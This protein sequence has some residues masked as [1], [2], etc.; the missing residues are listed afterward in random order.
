[1]G[2]SMLNDIFIIAFRLANIFRSLFAEGGLNNVFTPTFTSLLTKNGRKDAIEFAASLRSILTVSLLS[3]IA[4]MMIFMPS[5][6]R[7]IAPGLS[8]SSPQYFQLAVHLARIIFPY[9]FF[10]TLV[11]FYGCMLASVNKFS[12]FSSTPIILN[13][14]M[15]IAIAL[16]HFFETPAHA[17][18]YAVILAGLLELLW[19]TYSANLA[20]LRLPIAK[21]H[22][23]PTTKKMLCLMIPNV[24]SSSITQ[25]MLW[26]NTI[27]A[28]SIVGAVSYFYFADRII[29]LPMALVGTTISIITLPN[30]SK[31]FAVNDNSKVSYIITHSICIITLLALPSLVGLLQLTEEIVEILFMHG[32]FDHTSL[33]NTANTIRVLSFGLPAFMLQKMLTTAFYA[34]K[35]T[36]TPMIIALCTI[37]LQ[38]LILTLTFTGTNYIAIAYA[39]IASAWF[40]IIAAIYCILRYSLAHF[41]LRYITT[42]ICKQAV[43]SAIL[44]LFIFITQYSVT[45]HLP[46]L[47][48]SY[49]APIILLLIACSAIVYFISLIVLKSCTIYEIIRKQKI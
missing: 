49:K 32:K 5:V 21:I 13:V 35:R 30:L 44:M 14:S 38:L 8:D 45:H 7:I 46:T 3:F 39:S 11:S 34:S 2:T 37:L 29:Q 36:T 48:F 27:Y 40:Y 15:I 33:H 19:M 25:I 17:L 6:I 24:I 23:S 1:M 28:S 10:I 18:S 12:A 16:S 22:L 41:D 4:V 31:A 42:E 26:I 47:Y 9:L 43:A 20:G